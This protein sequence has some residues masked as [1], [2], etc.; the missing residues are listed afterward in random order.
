MEFRDR[1]LRP[2]E[3]ARLLGVCVKTIQNWDRA[4]KI[5]CVRTPGGRRRIPMSEVL[6]L[7]GVKADASWLSRIEAEAMERKA[8]MEELRRRILS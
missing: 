7:M 5:R 8:L 2:C 1:L 4:G 6:R 3:A